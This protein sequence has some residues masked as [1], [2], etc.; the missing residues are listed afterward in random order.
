MLSQSSVVKFHCH[1][2]PGR[3]P[4]LCTHIN[5]MQRI[6]A[7]MIS[8]TASS[9]PCQTDSEESTADSLMSCTSGT[10]LLPSHLTMWPGHQQTHTC[11]HYQ[12]GAS[13]LSPPLQ[14]E[15]DPI[16]EPAQWSLKSSAT[17]PC[18]QQ[19]YKD[20]PIPSSLEFFSTSG[21]VLWNARPPLDKTVP[22]DCL[23]ASK[24][25]QG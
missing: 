23:P 8:H 9:S 5:T 20:L 1:S 16:C 7:T 12:R 19:G 25:R 14:Q 18:L 4:S 6:S 3:K 13:K 11:S 2:L 10:H 17:G 21:R 22:Q 24:A 15:Q